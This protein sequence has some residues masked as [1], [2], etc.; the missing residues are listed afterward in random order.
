MTNGQKCIIYNRRIYVIRNI[1]HTERGPVE[2][3]CSN[4]G[5]EGDITKCNKFHLE[6]KLKEIENGKST[7]RTYV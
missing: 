4:C 6:Q 5:F 2:T 3:D 1:V 7:A